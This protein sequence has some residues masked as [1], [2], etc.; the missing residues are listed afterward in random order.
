MVLSTPT[1]PISVSACQMAKQDVWTRRAFYR[2]VTSRRFDK[3]TRLISD[4]KVG[5]RAAFLAYFFR[6]LERSMVGRHGCRPKNV[7]DDVSAAHISAAKLCSVR[8]AN[9]LLTAGQLHRVSA[10]PAPVHTGISAFDNIP[11]YVVAFLNHQVVAFLSRFEN[12]IHRHH[13]TSGLL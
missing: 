8:E 11:N 10:T 9:A 12:T 13:A 6:L 3:K 7:M 1:F 2:E 5:W 4:Q